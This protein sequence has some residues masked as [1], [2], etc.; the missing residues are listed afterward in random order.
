MLDKRPE[1]LAPGETV[2]VSEM[3]DPPPIM[4]IV[5]PR[6]GIP[7]ARESVEDGQHSMGTAEKGGGR[8]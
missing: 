4:V 8:L 5:A 3:K 6:V 1:D 7:L 2:S